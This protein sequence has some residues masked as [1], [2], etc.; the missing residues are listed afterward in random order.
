M[1]NL[2]IFYRILASILGAVITM[3]GTWAVISKCIASFKRIANEIDDL[4]AANKELHDKCRI[5]IYKGESL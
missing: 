3:G 1:E 2:K 5:K 4:K